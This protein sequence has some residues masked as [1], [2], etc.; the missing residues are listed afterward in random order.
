M[1]VPQQ[2]EGY[3]ETGNQGKLSC[4]NKSIYGLKQSGRIWHQTLIIFLK[5][6]SFT[7]GAGD[8]CLYSKEDPLDKSANIIIFSGLMTSIFGAE[9]QQNH[10]NQI[11]DATKI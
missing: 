5:E 10:T 6:Q 2:P 11:Y 8:H 3:E 1:S 4:L 7:P 9:R